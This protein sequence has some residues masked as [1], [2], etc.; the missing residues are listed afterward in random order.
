MFLNEEQSI[1]AVATPRGV[2]ALAIIR[3]SGKNLQNE[4]KL[5]T[6][7]VP[8]DRYAQL[9]K[10]YHPKKCT[11]LDESVITYFQSPKSYT[12][13]DVIEISCHGGISVKRGI[14]DAC[15]SIGIKN[16]A[17]GEFSYRAFMNGKI[18]LVQAEAIGSLISSNSYSQT[19]HS[20][21]HLKGKVS[22]RLNRIK[23]QVVNVLALI[24]NELNFSEDEITHTSL[25]TIAKILQLI[26]DEINEILNTS[27]M[28][29]KIFSGVK[30]VLLGKPNTG[31]STLFN[32]IIGEDRAITSS[33]PGTTR[34]TIEHWF[35]IGGTP[36]CLV[37]TAGVWDSE[38]RLDR[39]GVDKTLKEIDTADICLIID[40]ENPQDLV[41]TL[42][43]KQ[44]SISKLLL[45]KSKFD[46]SGGSGNQKNINILNVSSKTNHGI[47][48]LLTRLTK[49]I[50]NNFGP[51]HNDDIMITKRQ[52]ALLENSLLHIHS[53]IKQV[54]E[55]TGMDILASTLH[56]FVGSIKEIIGEVYDKD[57][58]HKI[59]NEFCVG[60]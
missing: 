55:N 59:F 53:A 43:I 12:G 40:D 33:E 29:K 32:S 23:E 7:K 10:I 28:G 42:K 34:D 19:Q 37:D 38:K 15:N 3:I 50:V 27:I 24:E 4:Y 60:K 35:E 51:F 56:G 31:K 17:K 54:H 47:D 57:I 21:L 46:L 18:D 14:V 26:K 44:K 58:I 39:L 11:V 6:K 25:E 36:V 48:R 49:I 52:V 41:K 1:V 13:E 8:K 9:S 30:I 20:L 45:I 2:G 22:K 16:A 5:L